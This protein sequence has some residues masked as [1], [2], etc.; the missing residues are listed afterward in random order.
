MNREL[1]GGVFW[2]VF[3]IVLCS[4]SGTYEIGTF[5]HPGTGL[6][7]LLLGA[8]LIVLS[9]V[10]IVQAVRSKANKDEKQAKIFSGNWKK[11]G[12]IVVV[13]F[14]ACFLFEWIGYLLTFFLMSA[15]LM[16]L[17]ECKNWKQIA[18]IAFCTTLGIYLCF[19]VLLKQQLPKGI[20]GV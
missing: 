19:V 14:V 2:L 10:I 17:G 15:V 6:M 20:L 5:S 9:I 16:I 7:P 8:L 1:I 13:L 11:A 18:I 4:W 3:G 12:S